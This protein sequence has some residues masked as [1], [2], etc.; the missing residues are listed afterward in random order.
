MYVLLFLIKW[1][2]DKGGKLT[3][4]PSKCSC[5][6]CWGFGSVVERLP[7]RCKALG[8]VPSSKIKKRK[9]N[10]LAAK[11]DYPSLI[12]GAHTEESGI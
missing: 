7:R 2:W 4:S 3:G 10:V 12:P 9:K 6:C 5:C 1:K 8:S 11:P